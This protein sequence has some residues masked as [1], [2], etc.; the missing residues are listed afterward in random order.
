MKKVKT[1]SLAITMLISFLSLGQEI[2]GK[3]KFKEYEFF[4]LNKEYENY[5]D[6]IK[7]NGFKK[8]SDTSFTLSNSDYRLTQIRKKSKI[9]ILFS[10]INLNY[11]TD[12]A[13]ES[14]TLLDTLQ[15]NS[16]DDNNFVTIGYCELDGLIPEQIISLVK[17][18]KKEY[19]EM[20][21][22]SWKV[23]EKTMRIEKIVDV[24]KIKC[25]NEH[26]EYSE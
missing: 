16:L 12:E 26:F 7:S 3:N 4:M 23:N 19:L 1:F 5:D 6:V 2:N 17:K 24:S 8:V 11:E 10:K 15:I 18:S 22:K 14:L 21:I 13:N 20:I 25:I 9:L